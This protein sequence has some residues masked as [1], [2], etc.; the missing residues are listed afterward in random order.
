M[1]NL[2]IHRASSVSVKVVKKRDVKD[3][4]DHDVYVMVI[5]HEGLSESAEMESIK[6]TLFAAADADIG[7]GPLVGEDGYD[8]GYCDG[9]AAQ[10]AGQ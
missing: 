7:L 5:E 4:F 10:E 8:S 2:N 3:C 9:V 1:I 6:V